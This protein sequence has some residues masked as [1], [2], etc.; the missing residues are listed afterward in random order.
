MAL[1]LSLGSVDDDVLAAGLTSPAEGADGAHLALSFRSLSQAAEEPSASSGPVSA[2]MLALEPHWRKIRTAVAALEHFAGNF[3]HLVLGDIA[4]AASKLRKIAVTLARVAGHLTRDCEQEMHKLLRQQQVQQW[5][6]LSVPAAL[7]PGSGTGVGCSKSESAAARHALHCILLAS[8]RSAGADACVLHCK[9]PSHDQVPAPQPGRGNE[10]AVAGAAEVPIHGVACVVAN[11]SVPQTLR[12]CSK[13]SAAVCRTGIAASVVD[14]HADMRPH[15]GAQ[16]AAAVLS[17]PLPQGRGVLTLQRD[18]VPFMRRFGG[19]QER[20]GEAFTT[21]DEAMLYA[22]A[23]MCAQHAASFP[24]VT[25]P[26]EDASAAAVAFA[27]RQPTLPQ[28]A[29]QAAN[30]QLAIPQPIYRTEHGTAQWFSH[31]ERTQ[32]LGAAGVAELF[33]EVHGA[34]QNMQRV[35]DTQQHRLSFAEQRAEELSGRLAECLKNYSAAQQVIAEL[36]SAKEQGKRRGLADAASASTGEDS[37]RKPPALQVPSAA[38]LGGATPASEAAAASGSAERPYEGSWASHAT[39]RGSTATENVDTFPSNTLVSGRLKASGTP[40]SARALSAVSYRNSMATSHANSPQSGGTC[41]QSHAPSPHQFADGSRCLAWMTGEV[42]AAAAAGELGETEAAQ[43]LAPPPLLPPSAYPLRPP[44][45]P[46][47]PQPDPS[48]KRYRHFLLSPSVAI[49]ESA[50]GATLA[51]Q[52]PQQPSPQQQGQRGQWWVPQAGRAWN[53][54]CAL[55]NTCRQ[56]RR[57]PGL[58]AFQLGS[59]T[60]R[61]HAPVSRQDTE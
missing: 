50:E 40:R 53:G 21:R 27:Q 32:R 23:E 47:P 48:G 28:R 10:A 6:N 19:G 52:A 60:A 15:D 29:P 34:Q 2:G 35:I 4:G 24:S 59:K 56:K 5:H 41:P 17:V 26:G 13:L 31:A 14:P 54:K 61:S 44:A 38:V 51:P 33:S 25:E 55:S 9:S 12:G 36:T 45:Q 7:T 1:S 57:S 58:A 16:P 18:R 46:R 43:L 42:A 8:L 20:A 11:G 49:R 3:R 37:N 22:A 39:R 30:L